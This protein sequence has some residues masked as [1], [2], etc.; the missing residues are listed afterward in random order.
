MTRGRIGWA[1]TALA[2]T[3]LASGCASAPRFISAEPP[4]APSPSDPPELDY[5]M[6]R[7]LEH[8]GDLPAAYAAYQRALGKDPESAFLLRRL[9]ELSLSLKRPG[10]ALLYAERGLEHAPEDSELRL[11]LGT[12][13]LEQGDAAA[14]ERVLFDAKGK[15]ASRDAAIVLYTAFAAAGRSEDARRAADWLI[16]DAPE[17]TTGYLALADAHQRE[18]D[19]DA[20]ERT[21]R[22]GLARL[23]GDVELFEALANSRRERGDRVGEIGVYRELL[24]AHPEHHG[25]LLRKADAELALEQPDDAAATLLRIERLY[26]DD[27]RTTLRLAFLDLE[28]GKYAEAEARFAKARADQPDQHEIA[29]F[30]GVAQ[31]RGG[32][33][34]A[35][36]ATFSAI[37]ESDDRYADARLQLA[38]I[39]ERKGDLAQ[40]LAEVDLA[41]AREPEQPLDL[42][43]ASLQ[44]KTG[45]V[46]GAIAFLEAMLAATPDDPEVLY[47]IGV[48]HGE[49]KQ[50]D[51]ALRTMQ[52]VIEIDADHAGALNYIGYSWA[53]RGERLDE[54]EKL[55]SRALELRPGDGFITDSLGWVYYMRARPLAEAGRTREAKA[56]LARAIEYLQHAAELTGG[57]PVISEHLG[58]V[59]LLLNDRRA[60]LRSYEEALAL[61]PREQE[62][63]QLQQKL[64]RLRQGLGAK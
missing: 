52:R 60:A 19:P 40:A 6:G 16:D 39:H 58:D 49:A 47:N 28:A 36:L 20:A 7:D 5:L 38:G 21:L 15:P 14:A 1:A 10:D 34:E 33:D 13:Y 41:R 29:Y 3:L 9:A 57:D 2:A 37:P 48:I 45:D 35:A 22:R 17:D 62:Q 12:I 56:L 61:D 27:L 26:P 25:A 11:L 24:E 51:E 43:R 32:K 64:E 55:I 50:P 59:Y 63:P 54:A 46:A 30:L 8:D 42:Y 31:R 44:A 18:K 53:E 4:P 23:P